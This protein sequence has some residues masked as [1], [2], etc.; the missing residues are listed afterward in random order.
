MRIAVVHNLPPGGARRRLASQVRHLSG[1]L[2]EICLQTATPI[3][4]NPVVVPVRRL[5]P[6]HSR[7]L[8]PPLRYVDL[9]SLERAWRAAA[10][11]IRRSG[12]EVV[13][14]NPC[15]YLQ[16]PPVLQE[17][18]PSALYF[19]DEARRVDS[20]AAARSTRNRLT[21][22][23]YA[24]MYARERR[25]DRSAACGASRLATNSRYTAAEIERAYGR[26]PSVLT[27][28]VADSLLAREPVTR[29]DAFLLS[30][31]TLIPTKGHD[32]VIR[33]AAAATVRRPVVVVAPRPGADE[34]ARL[35]ALAGSLRVDLDVRVGISDEELG[36][37][38]S[39]AFATL[40]LARREPLGLVSLEAQACGCPVIVADDGGLPETVLDGTTGWKSSRDP[41]AVASL[42]DRL[43]DPALAQ[44]VSTDAR[45]H[46]RGW[47]WETSAAQVEG[48][49]REVRDGS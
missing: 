36:D 10:Q 37:L 13:Y 42:L 4:P 39:S 24:P 48:L 32:L 14:L 34:Q 6:R 47:S 30:V 35:Q 26:R 3:T 43:S 15:R 38:Y 44:Q 5:A 46:A 1:D 22:P 8:R 20:E 23:L 18:V 21:R 12:A 2:V 33:A 29:R 31:G 7:L 49:L 27:M 11:E 16:G 9:I 25:L 41:V 45:A 40:Y 19:C 17:G 28:G